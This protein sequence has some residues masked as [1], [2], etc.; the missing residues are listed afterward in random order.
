MGSVDVIDIIVKSLFALNC[1]KRL[2][3]LNCPR[4]QITSENKKSCFRSRL[5]SLH[6]LSN[7]RVKVRKS[8]KPK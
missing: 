6:L 1:K 8:L 4:L 7:L 2:F 5:T 3:T